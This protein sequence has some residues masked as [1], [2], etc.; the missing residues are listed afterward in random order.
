MLGAAGAGALL[1]AGVARNGIAAGER[2]YANAY[3]GSKYY[4]E[5]SNGDG[6]GLIL[7][8]QNDLDMHFVG[9]VCGNVAQRLVKLI[10]NPVVARAVASSGGN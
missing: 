4:I 9:I 6:G 5:I 2:Q 8:K 10:G 1:A 7:T 3:E